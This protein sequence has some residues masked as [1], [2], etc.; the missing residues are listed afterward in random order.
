MTNFKSPDIYGQRHPRE[1][2]GLI[3]SKLREFDEQIGK[4]PESDKESLSTAETKCPDLLTDDFKLMFLRCEV[5]HVDVSN[6]G[7]IVKS[8]WDVFV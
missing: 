8:L 2:P 6:L 1:T 3:K 5:F 7:G 4:I